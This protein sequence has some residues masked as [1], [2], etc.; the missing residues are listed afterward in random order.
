MAIY[1]KKKDELPSNVKIIIDNMR[2]DNVNN[3]L[4]YSSLIMIFL[5][6]FYIRLTSH[7]NENIISYSSILNLKF[8]LVESVKKKN[9]EWNFLIVNAFARNAMILMKF[10]I[11]ISFSGFAFSCIGTACRSIISRFI[12]NFMSLRIGAFFIHQIVFNILCKFFI[13]WCFVLWR[14]AF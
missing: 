5:F 2:Y 12:I 10:K 1:N 9:D 4:M 14:F 7:T 6:W 13:I 8:N 11:S 3:T